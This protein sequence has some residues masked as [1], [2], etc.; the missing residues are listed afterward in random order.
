LLPQLPDVGTTYAIEEALALE[1][2]FGERFAVSSGLRVSEAKYP[3]AS[4]THL[5]PYAD[6]RVG[7]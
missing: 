6:V 7:F 4:R 5:L 2:R 1:H 3:Y